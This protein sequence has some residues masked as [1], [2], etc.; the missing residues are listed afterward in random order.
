[1]ERLQKIL[2]RA[3]IA[4]RR[5]AEA[6]LTAGRV[7]V[8]GKVVTD[9]GSKADWQTDQITVDGRPLDR[10][11]TV[12]YL[13][14]K[15]PDVVTTSADPLG[16]Q[17]VTDL[18]P[19]DPRV[20]P[21]GRLDR[22]TEGLLLLTNDGE[23]AL[24]LTHPRYEHSKEYLA[25]GVTS[26]PIKDLVAGFQAG[27]LIDG[28]LIVPDAVRFVAIRDHRVTLAITVH[29]GQNHLIRRLCG[30]RGFEITR[31]VRTRLGPL[32]LADLPPGR[33]RRLGESEVSQLLA[34]TSLSQSDSLAVPANQSGGQ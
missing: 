21:V 12:V 20:F 18:V 22:M 1:M 30:R 32:M 8:N 29:E 10:P 19:K 6:Y 3:G 26:R 17:Q 11:Q 33:Y 16:R 5:K 15:P 14:N 27:T 24:R 13:L 23:L 25:T 2:A 28:K 31:L 9:L 34:A 7:A 4:S